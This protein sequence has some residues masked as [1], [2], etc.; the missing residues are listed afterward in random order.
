MRVFFLLNFFLLGLVLIVLSFTNLCFASSQ[1]FIKFLESK[2]IRV[3]REDQF[4]R[5][6]R[7]WVLS[8]EPILHFHMHPAELFV[9]FL[10]YEFLVV[11]LF[12]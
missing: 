9:L 8:P 6:L 5:E 1:F 2:L 11:L 4:A 3:D 12:F 10:N 7:L